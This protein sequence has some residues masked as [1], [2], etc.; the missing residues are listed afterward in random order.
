MLLVLRGDFKATER[1]LAECQDEERLVAVTLKESARYQI[2]E[3]LRD[4]K[5]L[6]RFLRIMAKAN[7]C[8]ATTPETAEIF[9]RARADH[10]PDPV[11][12]IPTPYPLEDEQWKFTVPPG[13]QHGIFI[14][15][16]E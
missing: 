4:N 12:F 5:Q 1:A 7:G 8:I 3:Q 2:A 9:R 15:T 11:A 10:E 16:R 14:G 6:S 13:E